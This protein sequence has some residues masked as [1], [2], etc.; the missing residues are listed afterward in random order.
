LQAW[1]KFDPAWTE[2][3]L[4]IEVWN[5]KTDGWAPSSTAPLLMP[6]TRLLPFVGMD[7]HDRNQLF[8]MSMELEIS[9]SINEQSVMD[10]L[11]SRR[12]RPLVFTRPLGCVTKGWRGPALALAERCRRAGA[13]TFRS[14]R[15]SS[16]RK[17]EWRPE[18]LTNDQGQGPHS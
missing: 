5:R 13:K 7:F 17:R 6:G 12:C 2:S 3:L 14:F 4:G 9:T 16:S 15:K 18:L 10:C 1:K 11:R 8:P